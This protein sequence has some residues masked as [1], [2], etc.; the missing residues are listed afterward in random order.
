MV[1]GLLVDIRYHLASLIG[2]FLALGV[3]MLIGTQLAQGG[4]LENEQQ[5]LAQR[6]EA[7]LEGLRAEN[8]ALLE[9][10]AALEERLARERDFADLVLGAVVSGTLAGVPVDVYVP[11]GHGAAAQR[12]QRVLAQAGARA[13]VREEAPSA[14]AADPEAVAVVFW[15]A[16]AG[17]GDGPPV[18]VPRGA[19]VAVPGALPDPHPAAA[20]AAEAGDVVAA[21][22]TPLGLLALVER[23]RTGELPADAE[24]LLRERLQR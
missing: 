7:R 22:D 17:D 21:V 12:L 14:A 11:P 19:V 24:A 18:A 6:L 23:L 8:R 10:A 13:Q 4:A 20:A 2:V 15:P 1:M 9:A 3:G 16:E 5:R